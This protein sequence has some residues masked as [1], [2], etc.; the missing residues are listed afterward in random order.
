MLFR[1]V[2]SLNTVL[3]W[4]V[5]IFYSFAII[6]TAYKEIYELNPVAA[7]VLCMRSI[8]LDA[9][10]PAAQTLVKLAVSSVVVF[11]AGLAVFR[12]TK[13]RFYDYL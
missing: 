13:D 12:A 11:A 9:S 7:L 2:E 4:L 6:P 5:P 10:A 1:S 8:V 3:F